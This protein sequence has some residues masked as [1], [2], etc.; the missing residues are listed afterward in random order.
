VKFLF[1]AFLLVLAFVVTYADSPGVFSDSDLRGILVFGSVITAVLL[2]APLFFLPSRLVNVV[3]SLVVLAGIATAYIIHTDLYFPENRVALAASCIAAYFV[4]F[5]SF[6]VIDEQRWG[7]AVL[8]A[9]VLLVIGIITAGNFRA[10]LDTESL[11]EIATANIRDISF[12]DMP[13]LYFVSFDAL[14]PRSLLNQHLDLKTTE[15][16]DMFDANFRRFPNF[17][18]NTVATFNSWNALL[19][20]DEDIY[21]GLHKE[22]KRQSD[23]LYPNLYLFASQHPSPL[24]HVLR[25]NGYETTAVYSDEFFGRHKGSYVD[26]YII[27]FPNSSVCDYLDVTIRDVSFWGYCRFYG[28]VKKHVPGSESRQVSV[29]EQVTKVS[30]NDGPQFVMAYII[31]PGHT[32]KLF[33]YD[34]VA[35]LEKDRDDYLRGINKA[36]VYL[37]RIIRYLEENDPDAILFVFGD[38]GPYLSRGVR[39]EDDP[40]FYIQDR[41]GVLGGVYP[42][43]RCTES[44]DE[45]SR[46]GYMTILDAVHTILRCLSGGES[47]LAQPRERTSALYGQHRRK[48]NFD[49]KDFLYE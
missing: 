4:L 23:E 48:N 22:L 15:F 27:S 34:H 37:E 33:R 10:T 35:H 17:F 14:V 2:I 45:A 41:Y 42:R 43:D 13:N 24:L 47:A 30:A 28:E 19:S 6:R 32:A 21:V 7:G 1:A 39:L 46:K 9:A 44:F 3:L 20:L 36:A 26:K 49:Y 11:E 38:H 31:S 16:H 5:V 18:A 40:T 29:V 25:K 8:S 12:R